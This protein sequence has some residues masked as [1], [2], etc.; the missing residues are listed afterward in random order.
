MQHHSWPTALLVVL[1]LSGCR[2]AT[3]NQPL[4]AYETIKPGSTLT[5]QKSILFPPYTAALDIQGG[6]VK[7]GFSLGQ[8]YPHCRLE[9]KS[10][11]NQSRLIQ[12]DSFLI[13][14]V[15]REI[16][17]VMTKPVKLA[18]WGIH[19]ANGVTDEI[20]TTVLY[21]K[22]KRQPEVE[23]LACL[24]WE[25]PSDYPAHLTLNQI[26]ETLRGL[27]TVEAL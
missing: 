5:L 11:S 17:Y 4:Y 23:L 18:A 16:D 19:M 15:S 3:I 21:L 20:Y 27:M 13:Y 7:G 9:L 6:Q 2:G 26:R 1:L 25:D 14:K 24:H 10:Q 22:S 8:Y 12:P